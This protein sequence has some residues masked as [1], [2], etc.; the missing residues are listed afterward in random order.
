MAYKIKIDN[1]V[2]DL[3]DEFTIKD[4]LNETLDS[5]IVVFNTYGTEAGFESF[6]TAQIY[7][8][9]NKIEVK[10][11]LVD[12]Y[13][14]EI[15][16]FGSS[17]ET[18]DHTY[19]VTL[20]SETKELE[21]ITLPNYTTTQAKDLHRTVWWQISRVCSLYV[22][23]IKVYDPE[24]ANGKHYKYVRKFTL[25]PALKTRFNSIE[26]PELQWNNSTLREVLNDLVSV[27][28]CIIVVKQGIISFYDLHQG[29][30]P[31]DV[32]KLSSSKKTISS[33]DYAGEL[34]ID[35]Q[36]AIGHNTTIVCKNISLR[37]PE[38]E[39]SLT[40]ENGVIPTMQPI[41][42][43]KKL[44]VRFPTTE[45]RTYADPIHRYGW[46]V[47]TDRVLEKE[48]FDLLSNV[49][50]GTTAYNN[51]PEYTDQNGIT[52]KKHKVNFL[53]YERGKK[54]IYNFCTKYGES[55]WSNP[56]SKTSFADE[57]MLAIAALHPSAENPVNEM[58]GGGRNLSAFDI[59]YESMTEHSLK[60]GKYLPSKHPE[61][62]VF[63]NQSNSYVD[64]DHQSI[65]EYAKVN[66]LGHK[67]RTIKGSY[68][69]ESEIPQLG[70][71]IGEEILF[72]REITY[73]DNI[74]NF[75]GLLMPNYVLKNFFTGVKAKK[76]SWQIAKNEDALVRHDVYKMYVEASFK[77]KTDE[78][79]YEDA[80]GIKAIEPTSNRNIVAMF[81]PCGVNI[82]SPYQTW[83]NCF[84][85]TKKSTTYY[86]NADDGIFVDSE[87]SVEGYSICVNFGFWDNH[88]SAN[89]IKKEGNERI[90]NFYRYT[91]SYGECDET[92][93]FMHYVSV[94]NSSGSSKSGEVDENYY[95]SLQDTSFIRP[96]IGMYNENYGERLKFRFNTRKDNREILQ[97][98][99]Q[100]ELCSDTPDIVFAKDYLNYTEFFVRK[101]VGAYTYKVYFSTEKYRP[102]D[103]T[104]KG[105]LSDAQIY[106]RE[107]TNTQNLRVEF[108][109]GSGTN[110]QIPEDAKAW[111]VTDADG[112]FLFGVNFKENETKKMEFWLNLLRTR[113][114][115]VYSNNYDGV[116]IGDI[117]DEGIQNLSTRF[118]SITPRTANP[119]ILRRTITR[120][121][122]IVDNDVLN[123]AENSDNTGN[124]EFD[125]NEN[126]EQNP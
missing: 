113:D 89:Y 69:L 76:R 11:F 83:G 12:S 2:Y 58:G 115:K 22:P 109:P 37:A 124:E 105:T 43:V 20:F 111:G 50:V 21:R 6:D 30:N 88:I 86:P 100:F 61:N 85:Q 71:Y 9:E 75:K 98:T 5:A 40:D 26:C 31:I 65:F 68:A 126:Q 56:S 119:Q 17:F 64:L 7:D 101:T 32:T 55:F 110:N 73:K 114:D 125:E 45:Y 54:N 120:N 74:F 34:T 93:L 78:M 33:Q 79:N 81:I 24:N 60:V 51:L 48:E 18:D 53:Y 25:D 87:T 13:D 49:A 10:Y 28:D 104:I 36:N 122:S 99:I 4:E 3:R 77:K 67:I 1:V 103:S 15:H 52:V 121:L 23:R 106:Y 96:R 82:E 42:E 62:R 16:S 57:A 38:G 107:A 47:I 63:D 19:T 27:D 59:E 41:Y 118:N 84:V 66:R 35:M 91:N 112:H 117:T 80:D 46:E 94:T 29:G 95:A 92:I 97:Y 123:N 39:L 8:D 116:V 72:S 14:D 102:G 70:D 44:R 108:R 90:Q